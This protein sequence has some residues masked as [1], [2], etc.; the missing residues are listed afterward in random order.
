LLAFNRPVYPTL[1]NLTGMLLKVTGIFLFAS[2][3]AVAFAAMLSGY[4]VFTVS[5][6]V[7]RVRGD[8][9]AHLPSAAGV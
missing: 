5:L 4:Y 7:L 1:I 3:G 2:Y 6:A 8:L 9:R